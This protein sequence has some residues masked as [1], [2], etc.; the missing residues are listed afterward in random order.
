G[1]DGRR[2]AAVPL[3]LAVGDGGARSG[4]HGRRAR[5]QPLRRR[6]ARRP[7]PADEDARLTAASATAR[8]AVADAGARLEYRRPVADTRRR[9]RMA[10]RL[11]ALLLVATAGLALAQQ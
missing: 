2:G 11:M 8:P 1:P 9:S 6:A 4:H 7:R 5:L 3:A 10:R